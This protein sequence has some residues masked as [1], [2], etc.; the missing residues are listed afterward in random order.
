MLEVNHYI[1]LTQKAEQSSGN[2]S[3]F[4]MSFILHVCVFV[5]SMV[6][7]IEYNFNLST[8]YEP[9][10]VEIVN[11]TLINRNTI[12]HGY[13]NINIA[14]IRENK[15]KNNTIANK[16]K[17]EWLEY[18]YGISLSKHLTKVMLSLRDSYMLANHIILIKLYKNGQ[19][20]TYGFK[21]KVTQ[22]LKAI[23]DNIIQ[24]AN[25]FPIPPTNELENDY[26]MYALKLR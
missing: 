25:P 13:K 23:L 24:K 18:N 9:V 21:Q 6:T 5:I 14:D 12:D 19:V 4:L 10:Y 7:I 15:K 11:D 3:G 16:E 22:E 26:V 8:S 17:R 20:A 2:V 1:L